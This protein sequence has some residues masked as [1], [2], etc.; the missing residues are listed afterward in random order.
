MPQYFRHAISVP[1]RSGFRIGHAAC[2]KD[3]SSACELAA[4]FPLYTNSFSVFCKDS[5]NTILNAAHPMATQ[6]SVH[7]I[8]YV[9]CLI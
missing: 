7:G 5:H 6:V 9:S 1:R 3:N 8:H 2:G 4:V